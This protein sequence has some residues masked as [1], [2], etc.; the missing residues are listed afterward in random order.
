MAKQLNKNLVAL[1]TGVVC[2]S[3]VA[4]ALLWVRSVRPQDPTPF[5]KLAEQAAQ[6]G[7]RRRAI[8]LY[9]RA[10][11]ISRNAAH[12]AL[13]GD[14]WIEEGNVPL[15]RATWEAGKT[16][17]PRSVAP[18]ERLV[19]FLIDFAELA[20]S[21]SAWQAVALE[22]QGLVEVQADSA[23]GHYGLGLS[24]G[25]DPSHKKENHETA[26][27][28]LREAVRIAPLQLE[29]TEALAKTLEWA[30]R[31]AEAEAALR[32]LAGRLTQPSLDATKVRCALGAL[33]ARTGKL[34][35]AKP[36]FD[37]ALTLAAG[38]AEAQAI[39]RLH[40]A[41]YQL[42][43]ADSASVEKGSAAWKAL[44]EQARGDLE[45][46]NRL[47]PAGFEAFLEL[48][49]LYLRLEQFHDALRV[50]GE[51][52]ARGFPGAGL[53]EFR[54]KAQIY[55]LT[56]LAADASA[57]AA[58]QEGLASGERDR[59]LLEAMSWVAKAQAEW[60]EGP[61]G[62]AL[63]GEILLLQGKERDAL[64]RLTRADQG[65]AERDRIDWRV[66]TLLARLHL[67]FN[68]SGAALAMLE[69]VGE[70]AQ[71]QRP[72]DAALWSTYADALLR[73]D[74]AADAL[75]MA[76]R[77]LKLRAEDVVALRV[78]VE[79]LSRLGRGAEVQS[80]VG[81]LDPSGS[82]ATLVKSRLLAAQDDFAGALGVLVEALNK[83]PVQP[84]LLREAVILA[85]RVG[86]EAEV[87]RLVETAL[88]L[89]GDIVEFKR[90]SI[91]TNPALT[92]EQRESEILAL[93]DADPDPLSKALRRVGV[94]AAKA[95]HAKVL[96]TIAEAEAAL[97]APSTTRTEAQQRQTM[98][99]LM[100]HKLFA[101]AGL[102]N[103]PAAEGSV[104]VAAKL[105]LDGAGG[106]LFAGELHLRRQEFEQAMSVLKEVV[107]AQPTNAFA[108]S[109]LAGCCEELARLSDA[110]AF[111]QRAVDANPN[112]AAAQRGLAGVAYQLGDEATYARAL[113]QCRRLI[114][115]DEWVAQHLLLLADEQAPEEA[116]ARRKKLLAEKGDDLD[117]LL[118]AARLCQR[119][120]KLDEADDLFSRALK[121]APDN[122]EVV[123]KAADHYRGT[124]RAEEGERMVRAY[125]ERQP[126]AAARAKAMLTLAA[127]YLR[128]GRTGDEEKVLIEA[129]ATRETFDTCLSLGD[130]CLMQVDRPVEA[131]PWYDKAVALA[132]AEQNP[133]R[134]EAVVRRITCA[135][136]PRVHDIAAASAVLQ[137]ER[138]ESPKLPEWVYWSAQI[139]A[140]EG[141]VEDALKLL[142][143][144]VQARPDDPAGLFARAQQNMSRGAWS[145]AIADLE[146]LKA[147]NPGA[148]DLRP[149]MSLAFAYEGTQRKDAALRELEALHD[150]FPQSQ[151]AAQELVSAYV[152][153][154]RLADAERI[155]TAQI[156]RVPDARAAM[157]LKL[158][159][160]L[161]R[162]GGNHAK[163]LD[164]DIHAAELLEHAPEDVARVLQGFQRAGRF[165][166]GVKY[167]ETYTQ[168]GKAPATLRAVYAQLL[169][170]LKQSDAAA[171][172]FAAAMTSALSEGYGAVLRVG[173]AA[174]QV[175]TSRDA[176][177]AFFE[178]LAKASAA[179]RVVGL[180]ECAFDEVA[181]EWV[182]AT[183]RM[184]QLISAETDAAVRLTLLRA[185]GMV[186]HLHGGTA[187]AVKTYQ[188]IVEA[189]PKDVVSLN[190][191]ANLLLGEGGD[192]KQAESYARRATA[193]AV[194]DALR[195]ETHD[196]LG[197]I[198]VQQGRAAEAVKELSLAIRLVPD[199]AVFQYHLGEAHRTGGRFDLAEHVLAGAL[200]VAERE[201]DKALAA[202]VRES[203]ERV[204]KK[205]AGR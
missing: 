122:Q 101:A 144:Y 95:E 96:T 62:L 103:W 56:M 76:D 166:D 21:A 146:Q 19:H 110:K 48:G 83:D 143:E 189:D 165:A 79:A 72:D 24:L 150:E 4:A 25:E 112:Y 20:G 37:E 18:R 203:V 1:V 139:A 105:D 41:R 170:S 114:P 127:F 16:M 113:T 125:V 63:E 186:C 118:Q 124:Q 92:L 97:H 174:A 17:D 51:R 40:Q 45:E 35:E 149:R 204:S 102:K 178:A 53:N 128:C 199:K 66:K 168:E 31:A 161:A 70:L 5:V 15:A 42:S 192:L 190:N 38:S 205:D 50:A 115:K 26:V 60:A 140:L 74:R 171:A 180:F 80:I 136:H 198:L 177:T 141:R 130:F 133:R 65:Y 77:A 153:S 75:A 163:A 184:E 6:R 107:D 202:R 32:E 23:L 129:A 68:E 188:R 109:L 117:N 121:A 99:F 164:D 104:A 49:R 195:A 126:D 159:A 160:D 119:L 187:E 55:E 7:D 9:G 196:T 67:A 87:R 3:A 173:R 47:D 90:L 132:K 14:L 182:A 71:R 169:V 181:G 13:A 93:I 193:A 191:L 29:Y 91:A 116:L 201:G 100:R 54:R 131:A 134:V 52:L 30:E 44:L 157:W 155:L 28:S 98:Q 106:K 111:F 167:F 183:Q 34:A 27:A 123:F 59:R 94:F 158:R 46:A 39:A 33:L 88:S 175:H 8:A 36:A 194:D 85:P 162:R 148:L 137:R 84:A 81:E 86:Q 12:L 152:R 138:V 82:A 185:R 200:M 10:A 179:P 172:Q 176:R 135:V 151:L 61:R 43:V 120:R 11:G 73:N 147:R 142:D 58:R 145:A 108:L 89:A 78:K 156:N 64:E 154:D 2:L 57:A 197:W 22:A 69:R